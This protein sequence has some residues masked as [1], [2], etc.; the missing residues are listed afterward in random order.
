MAESQKKRKSRVKASNNSVA[1]DTIQVGGS[2]QGSMVIGSNNVI[3]FSAEQV[4]IL[5]EQISTTFR[6]KKFDGSCPYK[7]L[8]YFEEDDAN[9]FFGREKLV[10]DL[11]ERVKDS[12]TV[13][14]TGPSGSGKSSL[15]RAGLLHSLR[16]GAIKG[17]KTWLYETM[18]PSR[19]PLTE[20][21]R[22]ASSFAQTTNAGDEVL[23][24]AAV[25]PS[26]FARWCEIALKNKRDHRAVL[27]IDQF[28]ELFTQLNPEKAATFINLLD[29]A[30]TSENGRVILVFAM[31]SDFI[32]NCATFPRLNA[33]VNQQFVQIGAM[34]PDELVSA[35]AQPAL[36][37]G[38]QI[39]PDLVAQII[40][41]MQGEPGSLPLMQFA[42]KDL[43]DIQQE[44]GRD[45]TLT[46]VGYLERGGIRKAL[47]RHADKTFSDFNMEE[48]ELARSI[49]TGLIEI[50]RGTTDTRRTAIFDELVPSKAK[51]HEI[52]NIV[53]KLADARLI[54]TDEI[55]GKDTVTI[56][57]EK[58]IEA[59]PWLKKLVNENRDV[60]ALQN[61]ITEDAREWDEHNRDSSY[62]YSG[63][64]LLGAQDK[65]RNNK[66]HLSGLSEQFIR[67]ALAKRQRTR[68]T[69]FGLI[70][71]IILA[72]TV[73]V[74][75]F[76]SQATQNKNLADIADQNRLL[77][78]ENLDKSVKAQQEAEAA[79]VE[80][81]NQA[82]VAR[83][84]E[85][86]AQS[87][88]LRE[89]QSVYSLL[90][91][92]EAFRLQD[93]LRTRTVLFDNLNGNSRVVQY[94]SDQPQI[95][96]GVAYSPDGRIVASS[97]F[98][99]AIILWDLK[100][101]KQLSVLRSDNPAPIRTVAF[102]PDGQLLAA[103]DDKN[104]IVL[105]D[106]KTLKTLGEPLSGHTDTIRGIAFSPNGKTLASASADHTIRLWNVVDHQPIGEPFT[107]HS[108][109]VY[110]VDFNPDGKMLV[111]GSVDR[112]VRLWNV[113]T[114]KQIGDPL[115]G[116]TGYVKSVAFS[117]DGQLVAS[118]ST[119]ESII[120]WDVASHKMIGQPLIGHTGEVRCVTFSPDGK[121]LVSGSADK[122]IILW[123]VETRRPATEPLKGHME[124]VVGLA[125]SPDGSKFASVGDDGFTILWY[126]TPHTPLGER[127]T[128]HTDAVT[129]LA[130]SP[131]GKM[132]A[133]AS[134]DHSIIIWDDQTGQ[135]IGDPITSY[136]E[137]VTSIAFS[138]DS[139]TIVSGFADG[140]IL[141]WDVNTHTPIGAPLLGH[142]GIITSLAY[143]PDGTVLA[144]GSSDNSIILWDPKTFQPVGNPLVASSA[145][146]SL[147]FNSRGDLLAAGY[148]SKGILL[149]DI[150]SPQPIGEPLGDKTSGG[151]SLAWTSDDHLLVSGTSE[152]TVILWD[153]KTRQQ[154]GSPLLGHTDA[155]TNVS[156][157]W[158]GHILASGSSD[159][160]VIF[161]DF[162][163]RQPMGEPIKMDSGR[164]T[165]MIF[166]PVKDRIVLGS[167]DGSVTFAD[168]DPQSWIEKS[169]ARAGRNFSKSEWELYFPND[170]Y[171]ITCPQWSTGD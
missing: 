117:P 98:N 110:S 25:D 3:G 151:F 118:G 96:E 154:D 21:A 119:D 36:R 149:W 143:S 40:N 111:S 22:V 157:S 114:G 128:K 10:E 46:R 137:R 130:Y 45:I 82:R 170:P 75:V 146:R 141:V 90:L 4:S 116:H 132:L 122:T 103:G 113:E 42:L 153:T 108:D 169:C 160:T 59:W 124:R 41:D 88:A 92:V 99:E 104:Q 34:L 63:G 6:P 94:F 53:R 8:D 58:L 120:L 65:I 61:E 16:D 162:A 15:V 64:R 129:S 144:S 68:I 69:T 71:A 19:D 163:S 140:M 5:I 26:I 93:T 148:G 147:A 156:I 52:E 161:W 62:L 11:V 165:T 97:G 55:A 100:T 126:A 142:S 107:G 171:H 44:K 121:T 167:T 51:A 43:F 33:L 30:A 48:Q 115:T 109:I 23:A 66:V 125:F 20:L 155:V 134:N 28:E 79:R 89:S 14:I 87:V 95:L 32:S 29:S 73:A 67:A 76:Q 24:K 145:V 57:H 166:N 39:D 74:F 127:V 102:S 50:G 56:S 101:G 133:S 164:L 70:S 47:E 112:T 38:L 135:P 91:G 80:A 131:N 9:L 168:L 150:K 54:T 17:S 18:K 35:I 152:N 106:M 31:R 60:I 72:L 139:K 136:D 84:G 27:F 13:F 78:L 12:R 105:W 85:L 2:I 81:E 138:P 7:G 83:V 1:V 77:A 49:F 158:N 159:D 86:A 37:V 123:D